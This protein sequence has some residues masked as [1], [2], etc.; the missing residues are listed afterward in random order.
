MLVVG[1]LSLSSNPGL[2]DISYIDT[3]CADQ[4]NREFMGIEVIAVI[5]DI[6]TKA[7]ISITLVVKYTGGQIYKQWYIFSCRFN[8]LGRPL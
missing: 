1:I 8:I 4:D 7:T 6:K 5:T 2:P 3:H